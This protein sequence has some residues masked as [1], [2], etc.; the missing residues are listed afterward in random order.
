MKVKNILL[1]LCLLPFAN[2][3]FAESSTGCG[4]GWAVTKSM[5]TTAAS[6]RVSTNATFSNTLAMTSGTS[7]CAKHSIVKTKKL[8][9]H[10]TEANYEFLLAESS[11]GNGEYLETM[12]RAVGCSDMALPVFKTQMQKNVQTIFNDEKNVDKTLM[13][14]DAVIRRNKS[15]R[16]NCHL[17]S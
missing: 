15:L 9:H 16:M 6:T 3:A 13:E 14:I 4:L 7:G 17:Q 10:F 5:T 2:N 8:Q 1:V 11:I 12:A